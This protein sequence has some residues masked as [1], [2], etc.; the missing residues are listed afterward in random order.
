MKVL[1]GVDAT[2]SC[3][4]AVQAA[5]A[6][7]WPAGTSFLLATAI[8]PFFFARAPAL[9][10]QAKKCARQHLEHTGEGLHHAGWNTTTEV[11]LGNPRRAISVFARD[12]RAD[13]VMVGSRDLSDMNRL[14]LG[15]TT[16]SLLRRAPCSVEIVRTGERENHANND[17]GMKLLLAT[18]GS[19][20]SVAAVRSV[21]S[22]PWPEG[23][24]VRV[25]SAPGLVLLL[26]ECPYFEQHQVE[27]LN[28]A[29][30]EESHKAVASA[31]EILSRSGLK[32]HSGVPLLHDT[33]STIILDEAEKWHANMIVVGSHGRSGF[34][35]WTM[36][37]VSEAV[38]LH[39]GCSVEVIR[40]RNQPAE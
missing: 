21:T 16:Q 27:E 35:R 17:K 14:F 6:R 22:R 13:L 23:T 8:D 36:G 29:S 11:I 37:S 18:D 19:E 40:E 3:H 25:I 20:F 34:D 39:A 4:E 15:S 38:A 32:V 28:V 10:D 5:A 12:W 30:M 26:R 33:P 2:P 9:L 1:I 31:V 7:P 24:Q